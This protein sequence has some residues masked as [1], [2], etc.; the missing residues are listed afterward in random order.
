MGHPFFIFKSKKG[1]CSATAGHFF[2]RSRLFPKQPC[3]RARTCANDKKSADRL[4]NAFAIGRVYITRVVW[5][6]PH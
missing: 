2:E 4:I 3:I 5:V 1:H 6:Y